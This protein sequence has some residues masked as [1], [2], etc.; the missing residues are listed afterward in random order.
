MN[1][2][3]KLFEL[4]TVAE[5]SYKKKFNTTKEEDLFPI[6]WYENKDYKSKIAIITEAIKTNTLIVNTPSY[7]NI[8]EGVVKVR[9]KNNN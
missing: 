7:S 1:R 2:E 8:I 4:Y 9:E 6:E 3:D 5:L